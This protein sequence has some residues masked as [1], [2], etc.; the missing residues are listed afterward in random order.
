[1]RLAEERPTLEAKAQR[2]ADLT[3]GD[4]IRLL[5]PLKG[6]EEL[7]ASASR[8][9]SRRNPVA[10]AIKTDPLAML[11]KAWAVAGDNERNIFRAKINNTTTPQG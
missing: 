5:E 10:E 9:S 1:M 11:E 2:I 3:M 6:P 4:A 7:P 8:R